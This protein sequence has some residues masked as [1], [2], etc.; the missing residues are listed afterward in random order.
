MLINKHK[1]FLFSVIALIAIGSVT[2]ANYVE[3]TDI[4]SSATPSSFNTGAVLKTGPDTTVRMFEKIG[5]GGNTLQT[6]QDY[7]SFGT[8]LTSGIYSN[9]GTQSDKFVGIGSSIIADDF[10]VKSDSQ[11]STDFDQYK[12]KFSYGVSPTEARGLE[13]F[14]AGRYIS[15]L[16][17]TGIDDIDY[18]PKY[19]L[20]LRATSSFS[21][22]TNFGL[23]D[24]CSLYP[25]DLG[26]S[27]SAS[28]NYTGC[29]G[30]FW[31]STKSIME[32]EMGYISMY[33]APSWTGT[34]GAN[35]NTNNQVVGTCTFFNPSANPTSKGRC[36]ASKKII[37]TST[38][39]EVRCNDN[40]SSDYGKT[41]WSDSLN[42]NWCIGSNNSP[43]SLVNTGQCLMVI[44]PDKNYAKNI[45]VSTNGSS[46][47][48]P[49]DSSGS[50]TKKGS[51]N[52]QWVF[53][54]IDDY[55]Q[56]A[57]WTHSL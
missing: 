44:T 16:L 54:V 9:L 52:S 17:I 21:P 11:W 22:T 53:E 7:Q 49:T 33:K 5:T 50:F 23:G 42:F 31:D 14:V 34:L 1:I 55:G 56:Y 32:Y 20:E 37:S 41:S 39:E 18:T 45:K 8:L 29:R 13:A 25:S 4:D 10:V 3:P 46:Y 30:G 40:T 28:I 15:K 19:D 27:I 57:T 2:L 12:D 43:G 35:N 6:E 51:C 38:D 47:S 48:A 36:Y 24:S 26:T